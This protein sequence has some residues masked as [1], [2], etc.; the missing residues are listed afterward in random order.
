MTTPRA[1]AA[2]VRRIERASGD[3]ASEAMAR[4]EATLPWFRAMSAEDRSWITLVAQ[5]GIGAFVDWSRKPDAS[6]AITSEVF[7]SAPRELARAVTLQQTVELVRATIEVVEEHSA[8]LAVPGDEAQLREAVLVFAREVAFAAAEVYAQAAEVRGAWDARLEALL[9]DAL[10]RGEVGDDD[11]S[12]AAALGWSR[13][14]HVFAVA[15]YT[16]DATAAT[17]VDALRRAARHA[18]FDVVSGVHGHELVCILGGTLTAPHDPV[19]VSAPLVTQFGAGSVVVGPVVDDL[20]QA[21]GSVAAARAGLRA[22][23]GWPQAPRP[24]SADALLPERALDG[25]PDAKTALVDQVYR[26]LV[27]AGGGLLETV[28][29]VLEQSPSLEAAARALFVHANTVRY[30]LRR[31]SEVSGL[32]PTEPRD[33]FTLRVALTVGRL[34]ERSRTSL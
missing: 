18:G 16:P 33:A 11:L 29:A 22:S 31:I 14:P 32:V 7:G 25:D 4:V 9:A 26:P 3:L 1:S 20:V 24:V 8:E 15:G 13:T 17:V 10:M 30:R 12:R 2:T 19:A 27:E 23:A 5:R 21:A 34:D 6:R 28:A